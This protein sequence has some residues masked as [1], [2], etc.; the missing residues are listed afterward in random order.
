[1]CTFWFIPLEG[2]SLKVTD[3]WGYY[4][5]VGDAS[6]DDDEKLELRQTCKADNIGPR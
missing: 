5:A 2:P 4:A 6:T 3:P 1:M